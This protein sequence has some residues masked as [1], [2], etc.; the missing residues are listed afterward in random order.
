MLSRVASL[1]EE[2]G[3][4]ITTVLADLDGL[5][6]LSLGTFDVV[7]CHNVL[8]Y[9]AE[10]QRALHDLARVVSPGGLLSIVVSNAHAE[11][12]RFALEGHDLAEAL[13][14]ARE[15][16]HARPGITF[17]GHTMRLH[18]RGDLER[19]LVDDDLA[20]P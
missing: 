13:R 14:W 3:V 9:V 2:A 6:Q 16:P 17:P 15:R 18:D 20:A 12:L 1:S 10:T 4:P 7:L 8:A 19:W 5:E 11:P